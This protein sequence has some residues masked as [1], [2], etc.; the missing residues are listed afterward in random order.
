MYSTFAPQYKAA[1]AA[2]RKVGAYHFARPTGSN[3][4]EKEAD[5]FIKALNTV[6][7]IGEAVLVLD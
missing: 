3:T 6:G 4:P 1:K 2:G 7:A 5:S